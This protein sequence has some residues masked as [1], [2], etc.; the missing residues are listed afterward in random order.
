MFLLK[1][2]T[3][4]SHS[5]SLRPIPLL[6]VWVGELQD[7][8]SD[9]VCSSGKGSWLGCTE[10][11]DGFL[12]LPGGRGVPTLSGG[13]QYLWIGRLT[14]GLVQ[15][16]N[17][18]VVV[19]SELSLYQSIHAP[20]LNDAHGLW[21]NSNKKRLWIPRWPR[22]EVRSWRQRKT[23]S[24]IRLRSLHNSNSNSSI[25][26]RFGTIISSIQTNSS[27]T[28]NNMTNPRPHTLR[29]TSRSEPVWLSQWSC[30]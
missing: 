24:V 6:S 10:W 28:Y 4:P 7:D 13:V 9:V 21:F 14:D 11:Q 27:Q 17:W 29:P 19:N 22:P 18:S 15:T 20:T 5:G 30:S 2:R 26:P 23:R 16:L 1:Y 8:S 3:G 25:N 12:L